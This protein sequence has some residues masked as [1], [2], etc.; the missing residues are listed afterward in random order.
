MKQN[1]IK[2]TK[3]KKKTFERAAT[4]RE[5]YDC[6]FPCPCKGTTEGVKGEGLARPELGE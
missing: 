3:T 4:G 6:P 2:Q 1:K 5:A